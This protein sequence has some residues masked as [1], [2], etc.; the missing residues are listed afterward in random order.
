MISEDE[1]T[2]LLPNDDRYTYGGNQAQAVLY[3]FALRIAHAP[4][5]PAGAA[6][7]TRPV[8]VID[9]YLFFISGGCAPVDGGAAAGGGGFDFTWSIVGKQ[10]NAVAAVNPV[11]D[12]TTMLVSLDIAI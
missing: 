7:G 3:D 2:R 12:L 4:A 9:T 10:L 6:A 8:V 1:V 11:D 5:V